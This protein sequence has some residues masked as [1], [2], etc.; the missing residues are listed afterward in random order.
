MWGSR[1]GPELIVQGPKS[2]RTAYQVPWLVVTGLSLQIGKA[3]G[4]TLMCHCKGEL[5]LPR[6]KS[7]GYKPAPLLY[8]NLSPVLKLHRAL[9]NPNRMRSKWTS[10]EVTHNAEGPGCPSQAL[11]SPTGETIVPRGLLVQWS[12]N[13]SERWCSQSV[14][15]S[16][17]LPVWSVLV[18][19]V[20]GVAS[21]LPYVWGFS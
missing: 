15:I 6:S 17:T 14:V 3:T 1:T 13:L 12:G 2:D 9:C 21:A 20:Q 8:P 19:V 5:S 4:W 10:Q 7:H 11:L 18:S 16:L